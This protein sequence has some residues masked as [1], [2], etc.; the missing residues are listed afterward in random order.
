MLFVDGDD[1]ASIGAGFGEVL[2]DDGGGVVVVVVV[3]CGGGGVDFDTAG[4]AALLDDI[5]EEVVVEELFWA[6]PGDRSITTDDGADDALSVSL[7]AGVGEEDASGRLAFLEISSVGAESLFSF[8]RK[9]VELASSA[10]S[11]SSSFSFASSWSEPTFGGSSILLIF[12][13]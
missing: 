12:S 3:D 11:L 10:C 4:I 13:T 1:D 8:F 7:E 9:P 5:E 6:E 2:L